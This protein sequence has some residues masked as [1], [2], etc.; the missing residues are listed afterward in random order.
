MLY[1][2]YCKAA[3]KPYGSVV[4]AIIQ[5]FNHPFNCRND[6][7]TKNGFNDGNNRNVDIKLGNAEVNA[8]IKRLIEVS[9]R[10]ETARSGI[11]A[12]KMPSGRLVAH[13]GGLR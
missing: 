4:S 8:E 7:S 3:A 9:H 1:K 5:L 2:I 13:N 10:I 6:K 11:R 12:E